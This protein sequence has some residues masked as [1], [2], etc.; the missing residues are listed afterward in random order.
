MAFGTRLRLA[1][2]R[3]D[4]SL[5]AL[6]ERL[7]NQVSAQA[8]NKYETGKMMPS[9]AV[10][11]NL[12]KSLGVSLDF[13]MGGQVEELDGVEFRKRANTSEREKALVEAEVID[14]VERYLAIEEILGLPDEPS[15]I[16][17]IKPVIVDSADAAEDAAEK[18]REEWDIGSDP[19]PS[20]TALLEERNVRVIEINLP[21]KFSGVTCW[22]KRSA[23]R[24]DVPVIVVNG[25]FTVE[26]SRFTRAHELAHA[27]I[28]DSKD[29]KPEKAMDRFAGAFL[30]P[31]D[32]LRN[33]IGKIRHSLAYQELVRLKHLY[34]VSMMALIFRLKDVGII[35]E[36]NYKNLFRTPARAWLRDEPEKLDPHG[37]I[38]KLE[39]PQRFEGFV[40]RALAEGLIPPIKA[41][42]LLKKSIAD[43][44]QAV[45]GPR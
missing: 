4:L 22:A 1:R 9:S 26:R 25:N 33:E 23:D 14:H 21:D 6:A 2:L 44:E 38:A 43:V 12:A 19:I 45:K 10:L 17:K 27:V 40:Y 37:E 36:A 24:P 15:A 32:H 13:L 7:G 29:G 35:S 41:A 3:A 42:G 34:G 28:R 5:A 16:E 18:L 20:M 31:A 11:V 39:R 30:V 8:I